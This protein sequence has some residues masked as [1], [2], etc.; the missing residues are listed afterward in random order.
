MPLRRIAVVLG[1][2]ALAACRPSVGERSSPSHVDY[3]V[4]DPSTSRI[5]LPNDLALQTAAS[6][7]AGAQ[8][9]FLAQ[10]VAAGGFPNDQEVPITIQ[11]VRQP[12]GGAA[13][14]LALDPASI[15]LVGASAS[16][17]VGVMDITTP[18]S[19]QPV[20][21]DSA[22]D[23]TTGT[24]TLRNRAGAGGSRAWAPGKKLAVFVRGGDNG[25]KTTDGGTV[26][27]M[28]TFAILRTA[29]ANNLSL[30]DPANQAL[31]PGTASEKA[32]AGAQLDKIRLAY[33][34]LLPLATA[35][36][37]P[38]AEDVALQTFGIAP[39]STAHPTVVPV[40]Q[41]AGKAP[42]PFDLLIDPATGKVANNPA[43]GPAAEG[44]ATLDGFS[45]TAM[46]LAPTSA[47]IDATTVNAQ[48]VLLYKLG[49][50]GA[51]PTRLLDVA[52]ALQAGTP[53]AAAFVTEPPQ[54]QSTTGCPVASCST[55]IGLQPGVTVPVNAS[56][57]LYLP[58]LDEKTSYAVIIT[59]GV[60]D[61]AGKTL[62]RSTFANIVLGIQ[63]PVFANGASQL[64]GVS[65]GQAQSIEQMRTELAPVLAALPS[66]VT[67]DHV[68]FAHTFRT[69]SITD[70]AV[71]LSAVPFA[72]A[73]KSVN[74]VPQA[75]TAFDPA[76]IGLPS[77]AT[78]YPDVDSFFN[79]AI[80]TLDAIDPA[81]GALQPDNT[82]WKA[83]PIPAL[84]AVPKPASVASTCGNLKCAP[85][86]VFL[87]GIGGGHLQVLAPNTS[88]GNSLV[89]VL[90]KNGFVVAAID[91]PLHGDR[92]FCAQNSDCVTSTGA[93]GTCTPDAARA[94]EGDPVVPG[95]CTGGSTLRL[96]P[97]LTTVATANP[98]FV[99]SNFF[100]T[101]DALRQSI[102]DHAMLALNL[103]RPP[104]PFPQ[105]GSDPLKTALAGRGI[106]VDP[107]KVY[108]V[109]LSLGGMIGTN[110]AASNPRY[111]RTVLSSPGGSPVDIFLNSPSLRPALDAVFANVIPG[112]TR[113]KVTPGDPAFD[114]VVA[115]EFLQALNV[116]KWIIDPAD[117]LNFAK[118]LKTKLT[119][120]IS[121]G[122]GPLAATT[123]DAWFQFP[124]GDTVIP[125]AQQLLLQGNTE[126]VPFTI[127]ETA[128]S[129]AAP[130]GM[131]L[132]NLTA[133]NDAAAF[134]VNKTVPPTPTVTITLP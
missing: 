118:H 79:A 124:L 71:S 8:K 132:S 40:D 24:L 66:G 39:V 48:T 123:T 97:S 31:L 84:V 93:D 58:P 12:V 35:I 108:F 127:Y 27:P 19:P 6:L 75:A 87:H 59:D 7:P 101:R 1:L 65:N 125:N 2:A 115:A 133:Q 64:G 85:L 3:A 32:A 54:I 26:E 106:A 67:K 70:T 5:P 47:P 45:T 38:I 121:A 100:R 81:T 120:P 83:T 33:T 68:A 9:E 55:A 131:I 119:S 37:L 95:T 122:L 14:P 126:S 98:Y 107:S 76:A 44:L 21:V 128:G 22:Y 36:G 23:A 92:A 49:A 11:F 111:Q 105:P 29:I 34:P 73:A 4:F 20:A 50:S 62:G 114:P 72:D 99:S 56:V 41:S 112:Y 43:F 57:T 90:A 82:K 80:V 52:G 16:P 104:A 46:I 109:G 134:L 89:D 78:G 96:A 28:P 103:A 17:T 102:L 117:P 91:I 88:A 113:A 51:A 13:E 69:Q 63:S 129:G 94:S 86:V 53:A 30:T 60:K 74:F 18:T 42:L 25:V 15:K 10:L 110:V 116:T 77:T 61:V 130:H